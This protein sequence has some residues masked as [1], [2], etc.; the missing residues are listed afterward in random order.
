MEDRISG[1]L[2]HRHETCCEKDGHY[3]RQACMVQRWFHCRD[4]VSR[5]VDVKIVDDR[6]DFYFS[7]FILF[8][9][10]IFRTTQVRVYQS[11]CHISHKLMA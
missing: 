9:F 11:R 1:G 2:Q 7:L 6:L 3:G 4:V 8:Y 10:S 5:Q